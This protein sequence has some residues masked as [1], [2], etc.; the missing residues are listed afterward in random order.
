[1]SSG[2]HGVA[3]ELRGTLTRTSSRPEDFGIFP[4]PLEAMTDLTARHALCVDQIPATVL[5]H[6]VGPFTDAW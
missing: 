1:M 6:R 5:E 2:P 3:L 4:I